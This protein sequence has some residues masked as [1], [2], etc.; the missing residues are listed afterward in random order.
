MDELH[1][2]L[3]TYEMRTSGENSSRKEAT[4]KAAKKDKKKVEAETNNYEDSKEDMEEA[5]FVKNMKKGT[6]KYKGKLPLKYFGCGRIGN[7]AS[8]CPF[9]SISI[10]MV[11]KKTIERVK[12]TRTSIRSLF[13]ETHIKRKVY[14]LKMIVTLQTQMK[15]MLA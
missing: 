10:M 9:L 8:K 11:K 5:N 12:N 15:V 3:I 13:K 2:I 14:L 1:G 7:F 4:F 6:G